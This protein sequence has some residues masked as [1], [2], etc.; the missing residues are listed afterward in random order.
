MNN[1]EIIKV[2][3]GTSSSAVAVKPFNNARFTSNVQINMSLSGFT[4]TPSQLNFFIG[5]FNL[6]YTV[7]ADKDMYEGLYELNFSK[8]ESGYVKDIYSG[9]NQI[10]AFVTSDPV[11]I[12]IPGRLDIPWGGCTINS[13]IE[14]QEIPLQSLSLNL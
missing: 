8:S 12:N 10:F 2:T 14:L 1:N 9:L 7:G 13:K 4:F 5:D 11:L 6:T 3:L